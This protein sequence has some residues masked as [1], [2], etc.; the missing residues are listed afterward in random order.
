MN[1]PSARNKEVY[2][3]AEDKFL[4]NTEYQARIDYGNNQAEYLKALDFMDIL[5]EKIRFYNCLLY[6]SPS[7][8]DSTSS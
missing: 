2:K 8:R 1:D 4:S 5:T 7:P 3:R 6:T